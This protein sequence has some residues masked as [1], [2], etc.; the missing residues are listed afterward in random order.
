MSP[1]SHECCG[2]L[3]GWLELCFPRSL[4]EDWATGHRVFGR[5]DEKRPLLLSFHP[6]E[7]QRPLAQ[8]S[9]LPPN[10]SSSHNFK[11]QT[12]QEMSLNST[13]SRS[14]SSLCNAHICLPCWTMSWWKG[15]GKLL[16]TLF[17]NYRINICLL[18]ENTR[19]SR[20]PSLQNKKKDKIYLQSLVMYQWSFHFLMQIAASPHPL[21]TTPA[22]QHTHITHFL[23]VESYILFWVL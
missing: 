2:D 19:K 22:R 6:L 14:L 8:L 16:V 1:W 10:A 23:R 21:T 7:N 3:E 5:V 12:F 20:E 17:R 15:M 9:D 13:R 11:V 4:G 18:C